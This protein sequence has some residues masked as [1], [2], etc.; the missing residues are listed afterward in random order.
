VIGSV[1]TSFWRF[2]RVRSRIIPVNEQ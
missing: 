1:S 2:R